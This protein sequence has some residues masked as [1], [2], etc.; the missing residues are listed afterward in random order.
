MSDCVHLLLYCLLPVPPVCRC[1]VISVGLGQS[2]FFGSFVQC[3]DIFPLCL[4]SF[5]PG[6]FA[7][8]FGLN[9]WPCFFFFYYV[10]RFLVNQNLCLLNPVPACILC[11]CLGPV[12]PL[13]RNIVIELLQEITEITFCRIRQQE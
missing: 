3:S 10:A 2:F 7:C 5:N 12:I 9:F 6:V 8:D 1:L 13:A 4:F 11:L